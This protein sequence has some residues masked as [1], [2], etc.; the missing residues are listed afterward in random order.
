MKWVLNIGLSIILLG[1]AGFL[2]WYLIETKPMPKH[3]VPSEASVLV[4]TVRARKGREVVTIRGM[5]T[6]IPAKKVVLQA[7][8][9]GRVVKQN[10]GLVPGGYLAEGKTAVR[11]DPRDYE[12]ALAQKK[13]QVEKARLELAVEEGRRKVALKEWENLKGRMGGASPDKALVLREPYLKNAEAALEAARS[14]ADKA[15]LDLERTKVKVPFNAIVLSENSEVGQLVSPQAQLA[16]LA[17]TDTFWVQVAL[18]VEK[19]KWILF[20]PP[21]SGEGPPVK[22]VQILGEGRRIE[23]KGRVLRLLGDLEPQG[24]MARVLVAVDDPLLLQTRTEGTRLPLLLGSYVRVE[25]Q[26]KEVENVFA[27][28]RT[29]LHGGDK[30]WIMDGRDRLEIRSVSVLFRERKRVLVDQGIREGERIV[31]SP[32]PIPVQGLKLREEREPAAALPPGGD[33]K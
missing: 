16:V 19:L 21:G 26:G 4:E 33:G 3:T 25:I 27:L 15:L 5:G 23:R 29:A 2:A 1:G 7:E 30:V 24:R 9:G 13:A 6:V 18:P 22:V 10:P 12:Y 20:P 11:I 32:I 17:G 31:T 28:P 8:V 14:A